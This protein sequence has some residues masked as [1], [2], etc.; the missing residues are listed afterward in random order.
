MEGGQRVVRDFAVRNS[1][2]WRIDYGD[3]GLCEQKHKAIV[4]QEIRQLDKKAQRADSAAFHC[5]AGLIGW[6]SVATLRIVYR[7]I[8]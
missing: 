6:L 5:A 3:A 4:E 8:I 1:L 2:R 7:G